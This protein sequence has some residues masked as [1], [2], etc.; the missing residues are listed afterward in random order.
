MN[1][2]LRITAS[3][4]ALLSSAVVAYPGTLST[5]LEGEQLVATVSSQVEQ[6][7][8]CQ[9]IAEPDIVWF[10][11]EDQPISFRIEAG[12]RTHDLSLYCKII[13][14]KTK[15]RPWRINPYNTPIPSWNKKIFPE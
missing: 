12:Y 11:L 8:R 15:P 9:L 1:H 2:S 13:E 7:I 4:L 14:Q 10:E 6:P 5:L 3:A